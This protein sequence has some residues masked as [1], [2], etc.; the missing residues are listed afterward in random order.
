MVKTYTD[1]LLSEISVVKNPSNYNASLSIAKSYNVDKKEETTEAQKIVSYYK[2]LQPLPNKDMK[3]TYDEV[4]KSFKDEVAKCCEP[5]CGVEYC[6]PQGMTSNDIKIVSTLVKAIEEIGTDKIER[7]KELEDW[8]AV[9]KLP[10]ESFV[11]D[12]SDSRMYPHH[13]ADF[14]INK[15]RLDYQLSKLLSGETRLSTKDFGI[16][17]NHLY[18]HYK[19]ETMEKT[20]KDVVKTEE[21]KAEGMQPETAPTSEISPEEVELMAKC[22]SFYTKE[23]TER[24][25]VSGNDLSDREVKKVAEAYRVMMERK[26]NRGSLGMQMA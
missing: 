6:A 19:E 10:G 18:H 14:T 7:P 12:I 15:K 8:E 9:D 5:V 24:P 16:A 4:I 11:L 17:L 21:A 25:Q 13:N 1:V 20:A 22:Y 3:K 23:I 26:R 2:A